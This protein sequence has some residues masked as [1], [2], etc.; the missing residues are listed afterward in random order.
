MLKE[1]AP[2][3]LEKETYVAASVAD[4]AICLRLPDMSKIMKYVMQS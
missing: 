4:E 1:I 3:E 2:E